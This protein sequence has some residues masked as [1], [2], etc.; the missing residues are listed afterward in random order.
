MPIAT[1]S[2]IVLLSVV[3]IAS[4]ADP[5]VTVDA[6]QRWQSLFDGRTLGDWKQTP[7]GAEGEPTIT[8]GVIRIPMGGDLSGI[9]WSGDFPRRDYEIA[10]DARRVDGNDFFC[11]LTFPVGAAPCTFVVGGWRGGVIGLSSINGMDASENETTRY[12]EFVNGR[13]HKIRVRVT[14]DKIESWLDDKQ[15]AD[16]ETTDRKISI[17]PEV[18]LSRPLGIACFAT[19]AAL[20]DIKVLRLNAEQAAGEKAPA[21]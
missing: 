3:S 5:A 12:Q 10:L 21:Q 8:D 16:V 19:T 7:F 1:W 6:G 2:M 9:T 18:E 14:K 15:M 20:R 11:G 17:R 4:A 13:W